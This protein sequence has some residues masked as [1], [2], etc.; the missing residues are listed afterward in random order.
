MPTF[1]TFRAAFVLISVG[2]AFTALMGRVAF[3]QTVG[4]EHTIRMADR[5]QHR[6]EPI[7]GRRG[8]IFDSNG[9]LM[10]GTIQQRALFIDPKFMQQCFEADG[11]SLVEMDEA[12]EK[13]ANLLDKDS[14]ELSQMLGERYESRFVKIAENL[15]DTTCAEIQRMDLPGVGLTPMHLRTYP[16]GAIASHVLGGSG[17]NGHGLEGVELKFDK[18]LSGKNGYK[19][20][21]KD[22]RG[23][24]IGIAAED[25]L[26]P[27]H[28]QH[29]VLTIDANIQMIVEQE[30]ANTCSETRAKRGEAIVMD[31]QTGDVLAMANWPTFNPENLDDSIAETRRNRCLTDPYEPGSTIKPFIV[32]PA[33]AAKKTRI[34]EVWPIGG[35]SYKSPLRSKLVTDVYGYGPL[36]TW[37]VLV[38]S[39][40][41]GMTMLGERLR[42]RGVYDAFGSW[43]FGKMT[44][45]ELPGEDPGYVKSLNKWGTSDIVSAVQGY[46]VMVTPMQLARGFCAFG[47]GGRLVQPRIVKGVLDADG[48]IVARTPA[49][50]LKLMPEAVDPV[51]AAE[52]KRVL[53][54]VPIRGTA[55]KARSK[56]W[57]IFGKTGTAHVAKNGN[58]NDTAYTSS[59]VAGAPAE[60][61]RLVLAFIIHEPDR[62]HMVSQGLMYYGGTVAG[63]GAGKI[64]ERTL[65]YLQVPASPALPP[66]PPA[67][68][69]VLVN[70]NPKL[71]T[72]TASVAE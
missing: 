70:Y 9:L 19:R 21:L 3:L 15:D 38:K 66:P 59:F 46:S 24:S 49:K 1:S 60:R 63:P 29:L 67:I 28:G 41:V 62:N 44:G 2:V 7:Q 64:M 12:M 23:R 25:Y 6:T 10:A 37:D 65:S 33:I 54:D 72:Q 39:S 45:I 4:R 8:C 40:N 18:L 57:N 42:Q 69:N 17:K 20:T 5:Q 30:L 53:S 14:F 34:G 51:T 71:Y 50:D 16:M 11:R 22:S 56:T 52:V 36:S 68:A 58:Y 55:T 13:L 26:P 61:P 48:N 32:G 47:N 35:K 31:P 27:L 43:Q